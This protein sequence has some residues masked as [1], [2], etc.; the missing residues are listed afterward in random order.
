MKTIVVNT[1]RETN[2]QHLPKLGLMCRILCGYLLGFQ[3]IPRQYEGSVSAFVKRNW[4]ML[5]L[6]GVAAITVADSSGITVAPGLWLKTHGGPNIV[7]VLIF[8]LSG[9]ALDTRQ[10][11]AGFAD[12]KGTLL[13]LCLIFLAAPLVALGFSTL[14]LAAG[15]VI[16]L[17][18]VASMPSTLS[19][20]IVMTGEAGGNMAHALLVTI[21]ANSL[22][23]V[24]IPI[25]LNHLLTFTGDSRVIVIDQLPIMIKIA[26]LVL[27]PLVIGLIVRNRTGSLLRPLLPYTSICNQIGILAIVWMASCQGR[28]AI[29]SRLDTMLPVLAV[30]FSFHLVMLAVAIM[31]ARIARMGKGRR[32]SVIFMGGQKTLALSVVLQVSLFPDYGLALVVCILHHI[33]HLAM[34]AFVVQRLKKKE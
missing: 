26:T 12:Y 30:V 18:L 25:T 3:S 28:E 2:L 34:D 27:L 1:R 7:I 13:A 23:V 11:R 19:S 9:L 17:F 33:T 20:G 21:I 32:E 4:F 5:G 24:T 6:M 16:G 29:V 31:A 10:I 15:V 14:P 8:F 22:A